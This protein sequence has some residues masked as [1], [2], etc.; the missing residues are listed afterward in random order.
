MSLK[1]FLDNVFL[2][3]ESVKDIL[4]LYSNPSE[5]GKKFER[6][7]DLLIK[8]GFLPIY[9]PDKYKHVVGNVNAGKVEILNDINKYIERESENSGNKTGI[10]DITLYNNSDDTYIFISSK[11][12]LE[13]SSVKDYDIQ[14]IIAMVDYNKHIYKNYKI[15][16]LVNNKADFLKKV[17]NSRPS[18]NYMFNKIN[19]IIDLNDLEEAFKAMKSYLER[20][21]NIC[22]NS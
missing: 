17:A 14:D 7:A 19:N 3:K 10:S 1:E 11:F 2:K 9:S 4:D 6:C 16:I 12:Y 20:G 15:D 21:G 22:E 8:L 13:E 18:S 5:R